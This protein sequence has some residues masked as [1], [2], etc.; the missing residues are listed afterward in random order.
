[1]SVSEQSF[2]ST[3]KGLYLPNEPQTRLPRAYKLY[4]LVVIAITL[5]W[6]AFLIYGAWH[7]VVWV[8]TVTV[9]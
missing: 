7:F 6:N 1:M 3:A 9:R 8:V 4:A 2:G 5:A